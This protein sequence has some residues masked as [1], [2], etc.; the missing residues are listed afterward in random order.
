LDL[1]LP[2]KDGNE[3][4]KKIREINKDIKI[5]VMSGYLSKL[6]NLMELRDKA[7]GNLMFCMKPLSRKE[8]IEITKNTIFS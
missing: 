8:I 4:L 1:Q 2:D 6:G 7:A 3:L 5:C